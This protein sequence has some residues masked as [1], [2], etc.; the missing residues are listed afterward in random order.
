V[1]GD[2]SVDSKNKSV[3]SFRYG[4]SGR[5]CMYVFIGVMTHMYMNICVLYYVY[6]KKSTL[7]YCLNGSLKDPSPTLYHHHT[8]I[9][10]RAAV[11]VE[12]E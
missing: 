2:I 1:I 8:H 9:Y 3:Q 6:I 4:Y 5:M 10:A 12:E 11:G 7:M